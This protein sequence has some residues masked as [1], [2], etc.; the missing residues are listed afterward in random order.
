LSVKAMVELCS[1]ADNLEYTAAWNAAAL[2][3]QVRLRLL[4]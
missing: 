2:L 3:T 4:T 1:V